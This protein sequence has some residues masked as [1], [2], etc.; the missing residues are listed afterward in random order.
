VAQGQPTASGRASR[1]RV[2]LVGLLC[3]VLSGCVTGV[4]GG[5]HPEPPDRLGPPA[6]G[7]DSG[8]HPVNPDS[9][10]QAGHG[11]G[12]SAPEDKDAGI[13]TGWDDEDA[14]ALR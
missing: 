4:D 3:F 11:G 7:V 5:P 14:G 12:L 9:E 6:A 10:G 8:V 1:A 2:A 13:D